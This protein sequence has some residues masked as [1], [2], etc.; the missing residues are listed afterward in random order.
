MRY[1]VFLVAALFF[2]SSADA[3]PTFVQGRYFSPLGEKAIPLEEQVQED[4]VELVD[5]AFEQAKKLMYAGGKVKFLIGKKIVDFG[6]GLGMASRQIRNHISAQG[7]YIGLDASKLQIDK[8]KEL[9]PHE[10]FI[11][12]DQNSE[13]VREAL[14]DADIVFLRDVTQFQQ[15][16]RH[17]NFLKSLYGALKP[18]AIIIDIETILP[19]DL[20]VGLTD[21]YHRLGLIWLLKENFDAYRGV[22]PKFIESLGSELRFISHTQVVESRHDQMVHTSQA[23]KELS[24]LVAHIPVGADERTWCSAENL[25]H[26]QSTI[27]DIPEGENDFWLGKRT[28]IVVARKPLN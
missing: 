18:G 23:K 24:E 28:Y 22:S 25:E 11:L 2:Q 26:V 16:D 3:N 1:F 5:A 4:T 19:T 12:G 27:D 17:E 9:F 14:A 20:E 15:K 7:S 10:N 21:E 13:K 8:A 6:C